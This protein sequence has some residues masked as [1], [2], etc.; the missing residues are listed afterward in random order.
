LYGSLTDAFTD[1]IFPDNESQVLAVEYEAVVAL[2]WIDPETNETTK[3]TFMKFP[4]SENLTVP[5]KSGIFHFGLHPDLALWKDWNGGYIIVADPGNA[6]NYD[7][8]YADITP[9]V[10]DLGNITLDYVD[11]N[12]DVGHTKD[13]LFR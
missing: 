7:T 13:N 9:L 3:I 2:R 4:L 12:E 8:V 1:F 11:F 6:G 5:T 10:I